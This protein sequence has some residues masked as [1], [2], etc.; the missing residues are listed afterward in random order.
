MRQTLDRLLI[1]AVCWADDHVGTPNM[2][3]I[4]AAPATMT[5]SVINAVIAFRRN[6]V[7]VFC[8]TSAAG[9][10][11]HFSMSFICIPFKSQRFYAGTL[12]RECD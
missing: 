10:K 9:G 12:R 11:I 1:V 3:W 5:A 8:G 4:I 2:A 7:V 6:S